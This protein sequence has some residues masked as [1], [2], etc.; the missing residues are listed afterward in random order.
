V[1]E[2]HFVEVYV[3][4]R[5]QLEK[6]AENVA[7]F[8]LN[9]DASIFFEPRFG[10]RSGALAN[11]RCQLANFFCEEEPYCIYGCAIPPLPLTQRFGVIAIRVQSE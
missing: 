1:L 7:H 6:I 4:H 9:V 8:H 5:C 10:K 3:H 2:P 11:G